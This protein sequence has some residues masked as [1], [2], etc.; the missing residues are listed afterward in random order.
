[1]EVKERLL[2][3]LEY[4]GLSKSEF[5]RSIG[6]SV[7][8]INSMVKAMQPDKVD[9]ITLKYPEFNTGWLMTG[10]GQMLRDTKERIE[11]ENELTVSEVIRMMN[12]QRKEFNKQSEE[13][14]TQNRMLIETIKIQAQQQ[15]KTNV[16][17]DGNVG[18]A[19]ANG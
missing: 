17:Q 4:K 6:V 3:F 15:E 18:C 12:D 2:K 7:S 19:D 14:M 11:E 8:F 1:M 16:H 9:R 10:E 13:L 5:C